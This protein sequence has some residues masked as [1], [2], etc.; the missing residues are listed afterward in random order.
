MRT[1]LVVMAASKYFTVVKNITLTRG[2]AIPTAAW[3]SKA[4]VNKLPAD[5]RKL[6]LTVP[7]ELEDW[8]SKNSIARY[9]ISEQQWRDNGAE[10]ISFSPADQKRYMDRIRK[11]G[12]KHL[13]NHKNPEVRETYARFLKAV[14]ATR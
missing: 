4:W 10:I 5:L 1:S 6:V 14:A 13:T 8:G 2:G 3:I 9:K 11:V 12:E 7:G